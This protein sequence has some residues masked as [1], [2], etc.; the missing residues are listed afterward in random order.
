MINESVP[1]FVWPDAHDRDSHRP[2]GWLDIL[3]P[4]CE[5]SARGVIWA[6]DSDG[7]C[8]LHRC[9]ESDFPH[10]KISLV[11]VVYAASPTNTEV[12][13]GLLE[14]AI[15]PHGRLKAKLMTI[16]LESNASPMSALCFSEPKS[17]RQYFWVGNS[18]NLGCGADGDGHL[19]FGFKPDDQL[20]NRWV[21]WFESV[22]TKSAPLTLATAEV[23]PLVPASGTKEASDSW[24][25]YELLCGELGLQEG[26]NQQ[27][28]QSGAE[29]LDQEQVQKHDH[30]A[31][32]IRK[33]MGVPPP[34]Q[35]RD[36]ITQLIAKGKVITI[37]RSSRIPPLEQPLSKW[38]RQDEYTTERRILV[39]RTARL[40]V[41]TEKESKEVEK[42]RGGLTDLIDR[43]TYPLADRVRWIPSDA[44]PLLERERSRLDKDAKE[45]LGS[46]VGGDPVAF[47]QSRRQQIE[48]EA[49]EV[50]TELHPS[51]HLPAGT[52]NLILRSM[53]DRLIKATGESFLPKVSYATQQ[54]SFGVS[55]EHV[56]PWAPARTLLVAIA[57]Y[58]RK[59]VLNDL[60]LRGHEIPEDELAQ[61]MNVCSDSMLQTQRNSKTKQLAK[62]ELNLLE[63]IVTDDCDDRSKCDRILNLIKGPAAPPSPGGPRGELRGNAV[64]AG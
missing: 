11:I 49:N 2:P 57:E 15:A 29:A 1:S 41:F 40:R 43:L 3:D 35:L 54:F 56:A 17:G 52:I 24:R 21:E 22:W 39:K 46:L 10:L 14:F 9:L 27:I 36:E 7:V 26:I 60:H 38:L 12:L 30:A 58:G 61:A 5:V 48:D 18:G 50:Y 13:R 34:D 6:L 63:Q 44:I 19:N 16:S 33:E 53:E 31:A 45:R 23:P 59:A 64:A 4:D 55:S 47:V 32:E 8:F 25:E 42:L 28:V 62:K 51:E 37:D 20:V